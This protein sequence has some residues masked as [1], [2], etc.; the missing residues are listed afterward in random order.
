[1]PPL[2]LSSLQCSD[3]WSKKLRCRPSWT[4]II[5][6]NGLARCWGG[7]RPAGQVAVGRRMASSSNN[8]SRANW[9]PICCHAKRSEPLKTASS[10]SERVW[11]ADS[12]SG[13]SHCQ[14]GFVKDLPGD[15]C[16][17]F[18]VKGWWEGGGTLRELFWFLVYMQ[19]L[20]LSR[21]TWKQNTHCWSSLLCRFLMFQSVL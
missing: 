10:H 9:T 11:W 17:G 5:T 20:K 14:G 16:D 12:P 15:K 19:T 21:C 6:C 3:K 8:E 4:L 13:H 1:M 18:L 7:N 2:V